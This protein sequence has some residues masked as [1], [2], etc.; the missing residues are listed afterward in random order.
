MSLKNFFS[1]NNPYQ[2]NN[3]NKNELFL[4]SINL[5]DIIIAIAKNIKKF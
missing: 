3:S 2:F 1:Q 5:Q 4:N